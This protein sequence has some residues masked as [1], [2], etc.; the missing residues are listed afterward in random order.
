[1]GRADIWAIA[2]AGGVFAVFVANVIIGA[3][4]G[5][6]FLSDIAEM[7]ALFVACI[8]FVVVVLHQEYV[9]KRLPVENQEENHTE[10]AQH[11]R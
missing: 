5:Q 4:G 1:M 3:T 2:F 8:G 11:D 7:I 10:V 6:A 9:Q